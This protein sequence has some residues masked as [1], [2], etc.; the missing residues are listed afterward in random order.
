MHFLTNTDVLLP[1]GSELQGCRISGFRMGEMK[2]SGIA[3]EGGGAPCDV[4]FGFSFIVCFCLLLS[5]ML[6][7][8]PDILLPG[9]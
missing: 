5:S 2:C 1:T 8:S 6:F 4:R 9:I 3:M 7:S